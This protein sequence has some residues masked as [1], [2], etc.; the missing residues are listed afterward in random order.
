MLRSNMSVKSFAKKVRA[1][2]WI[3]A[4]TG[5]GLMNKES[6]IVCQYGFAILS[7]DE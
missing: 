2:R 4:C 5:K 3:L 1:W 6:L 7:T